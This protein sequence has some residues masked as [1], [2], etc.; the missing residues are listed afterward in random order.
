MDVSADAEGARVMAERCW[1]SRRHA[2]GEPDG[3][4]AAFHEALL[5]RF[6]PGDP[7]SPW[8]AALDLGIDHVIMNLSWSPRGTR[9]IEAVLEL[10]AEHGLVIWDPQSGDAYLPGA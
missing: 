5:A 1:R 4:V 9:A 7:D 8:M 2:E 10:A 3:R 6:P